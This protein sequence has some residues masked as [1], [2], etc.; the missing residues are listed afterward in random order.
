[1][2]KGL[3]L[4]CYILRHLLFK[5]STIG[6][7]GIRIFI[8]KVQVVVVDDAEY[9]FRPLLVMCVAVFLY[10]VGPALVVKVGKI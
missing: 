3:L 5:R 9:I 8:K 6:C 2:A 4:S 1:M 10:A 7:V